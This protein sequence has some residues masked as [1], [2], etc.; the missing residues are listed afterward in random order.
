MSPTIVERG[1]RPFL[2]VGSPGGATIITTVLQ[3]LVNRID[4]REPLPA[5]VALPRASQRGGATTEAEA[6]FLATQPAADLAGLYGH[7]FA[8]SAALGGIGAVAAIELKPGNRFVAAAE[9]TRRGGGSAL[10]VRTEP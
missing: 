4:L 6:A 1:G 10:V 8:P 5:A 2:A 3:V 7:R 9:P